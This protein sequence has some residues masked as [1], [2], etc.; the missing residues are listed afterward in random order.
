[1]G[2]TVGRA[3]G[4]GSFVG[5]DSLVVPETRKQEVAETANSLPPAAK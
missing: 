2:R 3:V 1:M 5:G 4:V